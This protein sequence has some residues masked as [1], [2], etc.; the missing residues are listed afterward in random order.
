MGEKIIGVH[1]IEEGLKRAAAGSV[2]YL[3]RGM[4]G[5]TQAL[6]RQAQLTGK[7]I[8]KKIAKVEMDRMVDQADHR[9]AVLDLVVPTKGATARIPNQSVKEFCSTLGEDEGALVLVLDEI[10]DP[11]NLGAILRSADQF[12]VSLVVIPE[13]RSAQANT[14]VV[15]VSSG[16]AQYVPMA[17]VTNL[18]REIEY[19]KSQGFWVYGAAMDGQVIYKTK[20]PKRTVL[21]MGNEGKGI[22]QLTQRLCD[23]IVTIPMSGHI[24]SLNVSVAAGILLYE[25]RRQQAAT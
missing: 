23:H 11:Q 15:K 5:H 22:G 9:G 4:G 7:V 16:A 24:D 21:V 18:N 3:C 8:V 1:A 19:L 17:T 12:S 25:V 14:T 20:F 2:L 10:T 6:E 13:R